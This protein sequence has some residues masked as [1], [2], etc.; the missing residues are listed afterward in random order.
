MVNLSLC[1]S[2]SFNLVNRNGVWNR[3]TAFV[4]LILIHSRGTFFT[5]V[6]LTSKRYYSTLLMIV[7]IVVFSFAWL[8]LCQLRVRTPSSWYPFASFL[9]TS[10]L[11]ALFQRWQYPEI[12]LGYCLEHVAKDK[13]ACLPVCVAVSRAISLL[14][15]RNRFCSRHPG[16]WPLEM[17]VHLLVSLV[18]DQIFGSKEMIWICILAHF[19]SYLLFEAK[20]SRSALLQIAKTTLVSTWILLQ[21]TLDFLHTLP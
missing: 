8:P 17:T 15:A 6:F 9:S 21:I 13:N 19:G 3:D 20:H 1:C 7:V 2:R 11:Q 16:Q 14:N 4:P 18:I 12:F 5:N 10:N